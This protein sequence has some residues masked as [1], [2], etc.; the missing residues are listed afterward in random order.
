MRRSSAVAALEAIQRSGQT[1]T[2]APA[3][4]PPARRN[5]GCGPSSASCCRAA[6]STAPARCTATG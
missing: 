2:P 5:R 4:S 3:A 1:A 6:T